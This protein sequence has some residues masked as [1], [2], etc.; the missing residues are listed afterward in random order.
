MLKIIIVKYIEIICLYVI[1]KYLKNWKDKRKAVSNHKKSIKEDKYKLENVKTQLLIFS[2]CKL[3]AQMI[4]FNKLNSNN[5]YKHIKQYLNEF[6]E[7]NK[8]IKLLIN[9]SNGTLW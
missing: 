1:S 4:T 8:L 3:A 9:S 2:S 6:Y 7:I 5:I